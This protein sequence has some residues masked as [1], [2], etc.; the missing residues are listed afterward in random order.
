MKKYLIVFLVFI[1]LAFIYFKYFF[2]DKSKYLN[3]KNDNESKLHSLFV[4]SIP[5]GI[6]F[7]EYGSMLVSEI[8]DDEQSKL[9]IKYFI[10]E[11]KYKAIAF[12]CFNYSDCTVLIKDTAYD[13]TK[14]NYKSD[15]YIIFIGPKTYKSELTSA[16]GGL[17]V[18]FIFVE[19]DPGDEDK[20]SSKN[21]S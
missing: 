21:S 5:K 8:N 12:G 6:S 10:K 18:K 11:D 19:F 16:F 15:K 3:F 17:G 1:L 13:L 7:S 20:S 14:D 9:G 2:I 4:K